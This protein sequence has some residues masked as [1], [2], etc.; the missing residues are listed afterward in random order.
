MLVLLM[1]RKE[2]ITFAN[3]DTYLQPLLEESIFL[4]KGYDV[5]QPTISRTF[6]LKA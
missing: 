3:F 5:L 6:A 4:W 2:S 1:P